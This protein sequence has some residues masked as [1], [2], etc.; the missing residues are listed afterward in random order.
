[1]AKFALTHLPQT[2]DELWWV[3]R[4]LWGVTIPRTKVCPDHVAPFDAFADAYFGRDGTIAFW[5]GSRGLSG[6]S[7]TLSTLGL[8]KAFLLGSDVNVLGGSLAQSTNVHEAMRVA[9]DSPNAPREMIKTEGTQKIT[10]TNKARIRPLTASQRTVRG[11]HPPFLL[12]DEID[13]MEQSI[14]DAA[15]GQPL[16]QINYM[17]DTVEPYTVLCS[18]WQNP[19]GTFTNMKRRFEER[20]LPM[21]AWCY[22][23]SMNPIDGWLS[24]ATVAA[25][26]LEIPEEMW[27]VE[28]ELGEPAIGNRAFDYEAVERLFS[29][30]FNPIWEEKSKDYEQYKFEPYIPGSLYVVGADWAK[31]QDYTVIAVM[32]CDPN[33]QPTLVHWVRVNRKPYPVM[34]EYFNKA[35]RE[36]NAMAIHDA[37]GLGNVVNDYIDMRAQ[38]FQMTGEKRANMLSE[39]VAAVERDKMVHPQIPSAYIAH[40]YAQVGDLYSNAQQ[41]HLPDEVCAMALAW[42]LAKKVSGAAGPITIKKTEQ[43]MQLEK[44]MGINSGE[45]ETVVAPQQGV[46]YNRTELERSEIS[47]MV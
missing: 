21:K 43:P 23:E 6:K 20:G 34:I 8:T 5:H 13:E 29:L 25:K 33:T 36:Y 31:E 4:A 12:L 24:P 15:L 37:T 19:Q 35:I 17:G 2:D 11:P 41:Y 45:Q 22:R 16:P 30:P 27:R 18:T 32:K 39:Y 1:M 7:Y 28:Y 9:L 10:L 44:L 14:L 3:V 38:G 46:V 26:K 47:F 42:K 40:K